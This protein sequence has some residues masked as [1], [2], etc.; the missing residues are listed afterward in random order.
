MSTATT[1]RDPF[2]SPSTTTADW[3]SVMA[4]TVTDFSRLC[5]LLD[6]TA[7][8]ARAGQRACQDFPLLVPKPY[9][10]RIQPGNPQDPLLLQVLPQP[11]ELAE[12][13]GFGTDPVG[14]NATTRW[15]GVLRKYPSR[16]LI[17]ASRECAVHCRFCFRRHFPH[18]APP[19]DANSLSNL[20]GEIS[21]EPNVR[22]VILS[23]GD[24]LALEDSILADLADRLAVLP[25][26]R[27]LRIHTRLPIMVPQ[28]VTDELIAWMR[29]TPLTVI[30]VVHVNH[31]AEID[32]AVASSLGRL[33]DA[34]VPVLSQSVLL[35]GVNDRVEVLAEL[36]QRLVDLRVMPYY[37][38][39][40]DRVLGAA[41][42]EVPERSGIELLRQL[43]AQLPGY[44]VPRYVRETAG[45][46]CKRVLA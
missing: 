13:S 1:N 42:F 20:V 15:P 16:L 25:Q 3:R 17:V 44:A 31:P 30:V 12:Q 43:R 36:Y 21:R 11:V 38:H 4:D 5:R 33:I 35:R 27:R 23:G 8:V 37:L 28:R 6:L 19:L 32:A 22:E 2:G 18:C 46:S 24:P 41:H 7:E 34:G 26:L 39:Q 40:L 29:G 14:E 9:L 10:S 45:D